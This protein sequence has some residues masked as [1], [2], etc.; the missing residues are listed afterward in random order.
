MR[1]IQP[2]QGA[3]VGTVTDAA[4]QWRAAADRA[5]QVDQVESAC[6]AGVRRHRDPRA[7]QPLELVHEVRIE[8]R[9]QE[10]ARALFEHGEE[11]RAID[12]GGCWWLEIILAVSQAGQ[13]AQLCDSP[14]RGATAAAHPHLTPR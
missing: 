2:A 7:A 4:D 6:A 8:T 3:R 14:L 9:S 11:E 10:I 13:R 5:E 1:V 12:E